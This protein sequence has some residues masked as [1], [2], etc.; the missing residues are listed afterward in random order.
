MFTFRTALVIA[1][2]SLEE[3]A[4]IVRYLTSVAGMLAAIFI[5]LGTVF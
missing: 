3:N 5:V 4:E 1:Q 2:L